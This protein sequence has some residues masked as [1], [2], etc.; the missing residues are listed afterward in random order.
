MDTEFPKFYEDMSDAEIAFRGLTRAGLRKI[1]EQR[2]SRDRR[3]PQIG[4]QAPDFELELLGSDGRRTGE[5]MTLSS[6]RGKPVGL[7]FGSYT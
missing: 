6:L 5:F 4:Q 7:I 1:W 2:V 3:S